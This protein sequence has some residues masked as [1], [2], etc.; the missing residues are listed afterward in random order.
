MSVHKTITSSP[1]NNRGLPRL[2][3]KLMEFMAVYKPFLVQ[4]SWVSDLQG[5]IFTWLVVLTNPSEKY[6]FVSW[7]DYYQYMEKN[8]NV[9]NHQPGLLILPWKGQDVWLDSANSM[10]HFQ[11]FF[12]RAWLRICRRARRRSRCQ[13]RFP[14]RWNLR[15][16]NW[17]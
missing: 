10:G 2:Y 5:E 15:L 3:Y 16:H 12:T 8:K 9:P 14:P 11:P 13:K 17:V 7:D 4:N 1:R 6:E